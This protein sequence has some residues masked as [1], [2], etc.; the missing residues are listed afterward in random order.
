M[1]ILLIAVSIY[2]ALQQAAF[3]H[4]GG[5]VL[6]GFTSGVAHPILGPDHLIAM[7]AVGV[8]GAFLKDK[9]VWV[10]PV[11]FPVVMA[12]GGVFGILGI[13]I[14]AIE[15]GIALSSIVIGAFIALAIKLPLWTTGL[16]VGIFA[17]FHG[18]AHGAELPAAANPLAYAV[19]FVLATGCLH[20]LGIGFGYMVR[21]PAGK[22][23][24]RTS[25]VA[26]A[27][28]GAFFFV[29]LI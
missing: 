10:L 24:I 29:G 13:E 18:H 5:G 15:I 3:A 7:F 11:V 16:I 25:G 9:A 6:G 1:R 14:P 28:A 21:W 27:L 19:G 20:L 4:V 8:W 22:V 23:V 2:F 17:I 12:I 26:I